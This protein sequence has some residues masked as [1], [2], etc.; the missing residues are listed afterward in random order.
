MLGKQAVWA[1]TVWIVER[2]LDRDG[3]DKACGSGTPGCPGA[4]ALSNHSSTP[5]ENAM[6]PWERRPRPSFPTSHGVPLHH[7]LGPVGHRSPPGRRRRAFARRSCRH[8]QRE[9]DRGMDGGMAG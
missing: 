6:L 5:A 9:R 2:A 3:P 8:P 4:I 7:Q 1:A